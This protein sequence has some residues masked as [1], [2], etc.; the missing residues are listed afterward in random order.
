MKMLM[1]VALMLAMLSFGG[2]VLAQE[3]PPYPMPGGP[4]RPPG[5]ASSPC[6]H[7]VLCR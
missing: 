4:I 3:S 1:A 2:S 5:G 7:V 6:F